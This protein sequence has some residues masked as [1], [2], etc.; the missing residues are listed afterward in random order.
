MDL[1]SRHS[2]IPD[3]PVLFAKSSSIKYNVWFWIDGTNFASDRKSS[4]ELKYSMLKEE[5]DVSDV[6]IC[7]LTVITSE[8]EGVPL[9]AISTL[10]EKPN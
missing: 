8:W 6:K 7:R 9:S 2:W 3:I 10:F 5:K 1:N 4:T